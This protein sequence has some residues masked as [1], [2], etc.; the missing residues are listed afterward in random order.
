MRPHSV[1]I[2][3]EEQKY[4]IVSNCFRQK[5]RRNKRDLHL[6]GRDAR[7]VRPHLMGLLTEE[8]KKHKFLCPTELCTFVLMS[9]ICRK[10]DAEGVTAQ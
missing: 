7:R 9:S 4:K 1:G 8:Q 5:N 2:L 6:I 10:E 3:T